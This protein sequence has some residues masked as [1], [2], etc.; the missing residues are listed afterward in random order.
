MGTAFRNNTSIVKFHETVHFTRLLFAAADFQGCS[1]LVEITVPPATVNFVTGN[2]PFKATTKMK[3]II[4]L[5]GAKSIG[6][7]SLECNGSNTVVYLPESFTAFNSNPFYSG[8]YI[9]VMASATVK[10]NSPL[11][12]GKVNAVYV[13]DEGYDAYVA[14][15]GSS[16]KLKRMSDFTG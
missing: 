12:N 10:A 11:S 9:L 3:K 4:F 7:S 13:P 1:N 2:S 15:W 14:A 16:T 6:Y 8:T 5:E